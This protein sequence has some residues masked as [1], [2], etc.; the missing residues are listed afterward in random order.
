MKLWEKYFTPASVDEATALLVQFAGGARIVAGGTDL[1]VEAKASEHEPFQALIDITRIPEMTSIRADDAYVYI[2]GGVTHTEIVKSPLVLAHAIC[3]A[4]SCGVIGGPQVRN[5]ATLG[6]NVAHAL[7]AGDGTTSLVALDAEA[8]V[9]FQGTR[10]WMP[11]AAL[12]RGPGVS[13]LNPTRDLLIGFRFHKLGAGAGTAFERIMRPQGVALPV[14]SCAVW[15]SLDGAAFGE[16]RACIAPNGPV[17]TRLTP[18]EKLLAGQPVSEDVIASACALAR[19]TVTVRTSKYRATSEYRVEMADV[20]LRRTL[21]QACA[22][23]GLAVP[24]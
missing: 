1:L 18:V 23:A 12:F 7:P 14:L 9:I 20:L 8:E 3:L 13:L 2:G 16:V 5:V 6:G 22:R 19:E 4:E 24:A 15:V 11:L 17:P 21:H 10:S